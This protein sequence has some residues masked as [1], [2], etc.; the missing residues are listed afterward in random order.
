M[1]GLRVEKTLRAKNL[2]LQ[3]DSKLI[4]GQIRDE[5][6]A[7]KERMQKYL[8]LTKHLTQEFDWVEFMQIPRSQNMITDEIA[9]LVSSEE[10]STRMGLE[11]EVQ[12]NLNIEEVSTFAIH[13]AS[14]WMT[15]IISFLQDRHLP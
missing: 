3:S 10:R 11:M 5:Y 9:K 14:G 6:E 15:P 1:I 7:K 8:R 12:K 13:S 2:L 4:I